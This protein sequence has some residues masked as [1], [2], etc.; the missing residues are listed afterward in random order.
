MIKNLKHE[1]YNDGILEYGEVKSIF[2]ANRKKIGEEFISKGK[3]F[4]TQMSARDS[5]ILQASN[6]GYVIDLKLKTPYRPEIS[7]KNKIKIGKELYDI[8]KFDY[9]KKNIFLYLQRV[10]V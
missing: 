1:V 10:G 8:V 5:D 6:M 2:N 9:T 7:S 3:L 4:Y